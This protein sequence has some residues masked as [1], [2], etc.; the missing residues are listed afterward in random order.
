MFL[1]VI[2]C[3]VSIFRKKQDCQLPTRRGLSCT[4][5]L[6]DIRGLERSAARGWG[7]WGPR[8]PRYYRGNGDALN[9][10]HRGVCGY[11][12]RLHGST[13]GAV[14]LFAVTPR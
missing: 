1:P 11:G 4:A 2:S 7:R 9:V 14:L 5:E 3:L 13:A 12:D 10:E 8:L 6:R